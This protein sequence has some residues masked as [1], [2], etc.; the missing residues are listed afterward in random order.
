MVDAAVEGRVGE[1]EGVQ[2]K[3]EGEDK[4]LVDVDGHLDL[5]WCWA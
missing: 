3:K 2:F 5:F 4:R 1:G